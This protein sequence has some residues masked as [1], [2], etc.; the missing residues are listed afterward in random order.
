MAAFALSTL[1]FLAMLIFLG[2]LVNPRG[3]FDVSIFEPVLPNTRREKINLLKASPGPIDALMLGSSRMLFFD[4]EEAEKLSGLRFF[5]LGVFTAQTEDCYALL[6]YAVSRLGVRPRLVLWGIEECNFSDRPFDDGLFDLNTRLYRQLNPESIHPF[7]LLNQVSTIIDIGYMQE[8]LKSVAF[9]LKKNK[10]KELSFD[11]FGFGRATVSDRKMREGTY[12]LSEAIDRSYRNYLVS[13]GRQ[14][15]LSPV[16]KKYFEQTLRFCKNNG[17]RLII[18]STPFQS[19]MRDALNGDGSLDALHGELLAYM[20]QMGQ[21][22]PFTYCDFSRTEYF[23]GSEK[24][25]YDG[26][27]AT[28]RNLGRI[29]RIIFGRE[30]GFTGGAGREPAIPEGNPGR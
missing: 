9:T 14:A 20:G 13:Y 27:H 21:K 10:E 11:P 8:S 29:A 3:K 23:G 7:F 19:R 25:F 4:R 22:Y 5:N 26:D 28:A 6:T 17:I 18:F 30:G 24:D 15:R 1:S 2:I 12:S 16:R